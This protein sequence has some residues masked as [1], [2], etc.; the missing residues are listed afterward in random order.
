MFYRKKIYVA[1]DVDND[2]QFYQLMRTWRQKD[3]SGFNF[4]DGHD[5]VLS[6][7]LTGEEGTKR[8]LRERLHKTR[9]FVLLVGSQTRYYYKFVRWEIEEAL[10]M[11]L[12]IIAI[13]LNGL[14][15]I[16]RENCPPVL[17]KV[18]ALH[19]SFNASILEKALFSWELLHY[20]Y[21]KKVN[22]RVFS[23]QP[24]VYH[25]LGL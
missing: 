22:N 25:E 11:N 13:N 23:Y 16:D 7:I 5:L 17:R 8:A 20:R 2:Y 21:Q 1:F 10:K 12:P 15:N 24:S 6:K 19:I 18:R 4:Y 9:V 14:R 3:Q